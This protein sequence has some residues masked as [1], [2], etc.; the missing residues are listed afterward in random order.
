[1]LR[2]IFTSDY[3]IH[4]NGDGSPQ[5]LMVESTRRNLECFREFGAKLTIMADVAEIERFRRF[6]D[7]TGEDRFGSRAICDQLRSAVTA[8]HDVQLHVHPS[9]YEAEWR[10]GRWMQDY[11]HYDLTRLGPQRLV[12]VID[13]GKRFLEDL[14]RPVK[15]GYRCT[16]FRAANW[17]LQPSGDLVRALID[18][19]I[20]IDTSVF[21]YG[22]RTDLVQFDYTEAWSPVI[23]WPVSAADVC[24]RDPRGRLFECPIYSEARFLPAF[25][26]L[27]RISRVVASRRHRLGAG[28]SRPCAVRRSWWDRLWRVWRRH[29]WKLD[30]NQCSGR[31]L[32]RGLERAAANVPAAACDI[33]VVLI[34]HSKLYDDRN[35][36]SLR[37]FLKYVANRADRFSFATFGAVDLDAVRRAYHG[38]TA[39]ALS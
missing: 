24:A 1:M 11:D 4:G 14:L 12:A 32:I 10:D 39:G 3:E 36:R 21:K 7:E 28:A 13:R 8:G 18:N 5:E 27:G 38:D 34:G 26:S 9:Y 25:A 20:L 37:P 2:I 16:V 33:P 30:Y 6:A 23:P 35:S 29:A 17:S 15:S 22:R 19:G 31:Q